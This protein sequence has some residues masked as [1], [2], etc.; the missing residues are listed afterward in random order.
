MALPI[1]ADRRPIAARSWRASQ[2]VTDWLVRRGA[3]AHDVSIAGMIA[4]LAAMFTAYV[5]AVGK[6]AGA[7]QEFVGPFAKPQRMWCVV[8]CAAWCGLALA[9]WVPTQL[10]AIVLGVIAVGS[11]VTAGRRLWRIAGR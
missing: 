2:V 1:E 3:S 8:A 7:G 9:E 10:P 11:L 6:G 4:A 5:R